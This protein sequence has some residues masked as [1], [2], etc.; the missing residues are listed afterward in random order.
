M[1]AVT[2][3]PRVERILNE[4]SER[5]ARLTARTVSRLRRLGVDDVPETPP[6]RSPALPPPGPGTR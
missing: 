4:Y 3:D 1:P 2:N 5:V 6:R